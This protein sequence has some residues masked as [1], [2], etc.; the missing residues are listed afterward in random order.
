MQE[1]GFT[2]CRGDRRGFVAVDREGTVYSLSRW[3]GIK[4]KDLKARLGDPALLPYIATA[5]EAKSAERPELNH[6]HLLAQFDAKMEGLLRQKERLKDSQ[7][8]ERFALR[9][10]HLV[11]KQVRIQE[12]QQN[13]TGLRGLWNF[14]KGNRQELIATHAAALDIVAEA[15]QLEALR[16][17]KQQRDVRRTLQDKI[18]VLQSWRDVEFGRVNKPVP[19]KTADPHVPNAEELRLAA[20]V[21]ENPELV[22]DIITDQKAKFTRNDILCRLS[23]YIPDQAEHQRAASAVMLTENLVLVDDGPTPKYTTRDFLAHETRMAD[24][25]KTMASTKPFGVSPGNLKSAIQ[26]QNKAL[27]K[28]VGADLSEEQ[29]RAITH[30]VNRRQLCAVIGF[31]GSGKSTMLFAA[32]D[33]WEKQGY[34]VIGAALAGKAADSLQNASGIPSRT[35]ASYELS[36]KN[37]RNLLQPGD[38]VVVDEAGMVASRQLARFIEEAH[39]RHAKMVLVGDP[40]QLQPINAGTPFRDITDQIGCAKLTEIRR[41]KSAWQ[42]QASFDLAQ[43]RVAEALAAYDAHGAV[44]TEATHEEAIATLVEDYMVDWELNG[45]E[46]SRLT[47]A[48]RR[49]DVR[50]LNE[51][52]RA[53]RKSAGELRNEV[54][55]KTDHGLRAFAAGDRI[56]L[57]RNDAHLGVKNGMLGTVI[58]VG[59]LAP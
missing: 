15:A 10:K 25:A 35:L 31:A 57:T 36:W 27:Q 11:Q 59:V 14:I 49:V 28:S 4:T 38:V 1:H 18:T 5:S 32:R 50:A 7:R 48:H 3:L 16:M 26:T 55:Y 41:Q 53:A 45:T 9:D 24:I 8:R 51:G 46:T 40:D 43:G 6:D 54:S 39:K 44:Q 42:R 22:L 21:R 12:L 47:L 52:I 34:R 23:K 30:L 13:L 2:L 56:L 29:R 33:A 58:N 17:S 19:S 20:R 37:G